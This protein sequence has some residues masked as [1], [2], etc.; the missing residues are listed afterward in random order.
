MT[1]HESQI[2]VAEGYCSA[3]LIK[4]IKSADENPEYVI[5]KAKGINEATA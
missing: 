4:S 1:L 3:C 2:L 5:I